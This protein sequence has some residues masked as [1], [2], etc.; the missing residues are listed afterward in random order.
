MY[1]RLVSRRL[2]VK[3]IC[4]PQ[5][6]GLPTVWISILPQFEKTDLLR[7]PVHVSHISSIGNMIPPLMSIPNQLKESIILRSILEAGGPSKSCFSN[8]PG[9]VLDLSGEIQRILGM[10]GIT[11]KKIFPHK[12]SAYL[13]AGLPVVV[14]DYLSNA[15]YIREKKGSVCSLQSRKKPIVWFKTAQK[16][17]Y[18]QMVQKAQHTSYLIRQWLLYK[19]IIC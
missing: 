16:E 7:N 9:K 5:S 2:T 6:C 11:T 17:E 14:P 13:S 15:D 3:K 12:L 8:F 4:G 19:E 1:H 10:S 18:A